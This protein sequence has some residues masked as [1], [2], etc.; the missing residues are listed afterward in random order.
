MPTAQYQ[1]INMTVNDLSRISLPPFQRKFVWGKSKKEAFITT[2]HE[3]LPFGAVLVYPESQ[4][5]DAKLLILDGQQRLSTIREFQ[6]NPLRFWKPLNIDEYQEKLSIINTLLPADRQITEDDLDNLLTMKETDLYDWLDDQID[7]KENRKETR[8]IIQGIKAAM[9]K[10][11]DLEHLQIPAIEYLGNKNRIAEVFSNLNQGGIPLSKYEIFSAAWIHTEISLLPPEQSELQDA[12]LNYV[13]QHYAIMSQNTEFELEGFSE[14][15]FTQNRVITLSELGIALGMYV[16]DH[17]KSLVPQTENAALELGFGILGIS[18]GVDN[19]QLANLIDHVES[20]RTNLQFTMEKVERI[21]NQLQDVFFK[22]LKRFKANKSDEFAQGLSTTFKTLSYFAALWDLDPNSPEYLRTL[23][24]I[25][26][27]YV[28]DFLTKA[29][30]SHGDQRLLDFYPASKKRNYLEKLDRQR[31]IDA[32]GR[33]LSDCTP[34]INF[35]KDVTALV[36][37]HANLTYLSQTVPYGESFELEHIIAKKII[38]AHDNASN[39]QIYGSALGNCM[40]LPRLDNNRKKDKNLYQVNANGKYDELITQS[41]YF[42]E[43][44]FRTA[45]SALE[46]NDFDTTNGLIDKR[47]HAVAEAIVDALLSV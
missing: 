14:D 23:K 11:V 2:L 10:F 45:I 28:Y 42:T 15:E 35:S 24:N 21:C 8:S 26:A 38:N 9:A 41:L 31:F 25:K 5:T 30:S 19:R 22:I 33:W 17:I 7:D 1:V 37:I 34:G 29:W 27:Y 46:S 32:F 16:R 39:R 20:I 6:R 3:G 43:D 4:A 47:G 18:T 12:L 36:T 44:E 40:Y 13:K